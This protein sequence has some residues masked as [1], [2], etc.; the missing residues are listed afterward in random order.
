MIPAGSVAFTIVWAVICLVGVVVV[1]AYGTQDPQANLPP[2]WAHVGISS[3]SFL[4]WVY[5]LGGPFEL[6]GIYVPFVGSLL[7]LAWITGTVVLSASGF[8]R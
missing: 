7:V 3:A 5:T 8:N 4:I 1:R 2:D 6:A